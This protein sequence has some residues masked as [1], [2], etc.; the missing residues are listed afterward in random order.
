[1]D[2]MH[3]LLKDVDQL[4][5]DSDARRKVEEMA[6][7]MDITM[8][9]SAS[10][11]TTRKKPNNSSRVSTS[12]AGRIGFIGAGQMGEALICGFVNAGMCTPD[13]ISVSVRSE[14][15]SQRM[16]SLGVQVFGDATLGGAA[17]LAE[18][19][20]TIFL[21]VK[22]QYLD[23]VIESLK[24]HV[25]ERHLIVSIAAGVR[26]ASLEANL[27]GGTR[28][29]RVMPNTPCLIG[30]AASAYVLGNNATGE[31][32]EKVFALISSCGLA[33]NVEERMMDAVTGLSGSGPAYVF[34]FLEAM[35]D[36]AV[37][38][39]LPREKAMVL[40]A[41]TVA[42]AARMVLESSSDGTL[43]HPAL[44]KDRVAS[45]AGTTI[46]GLTELESAGM[47]GI[48]MRAVKAAA[49]RSEDMG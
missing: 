42:G 2:A 32:A 37:A 49:K 34:L 1:M 13:R 36:G 5:G 22:P 16:L 8:S 11:R 31:D 20:D 35:A 33:V 23:R 24:P 18:V 26:L 27:P 28:V 39:G 25:K 17:E 41:Q 30:Q 4:N 14:E 46:A 19:V 44:L 12:S 45:P 15:R 21:S 47:R 6:T 7:Q 40:A 48:I 10:R 3:M 29:I 43:T 38:A 9:A